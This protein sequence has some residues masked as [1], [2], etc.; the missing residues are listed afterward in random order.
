M[1]SEFHFFLSITDASFIF[2]WDQCLSSHTGPTWTYSLTWSWE[3]MLLMIGFRWVLEYT[4][5]SSLPEK[6]HAFNFKDNILSCGKISK[7]LN[8]S[9]NIIMDSNKHQISVKSEVHY[10]AIINTGEAMSVITNHSTIC[11]LWLFPLSWY[12]IFFKKIIEWVEIQFI[13]LHRSK[14]YSKC[15]YNVGSCFPKA[16]EVI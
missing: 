7:P 2:S 4:V 11:S 6:N 1:H 12:P 13:N 14:Y 16:S 3:K 8:M 5:S 10:L 9:W 15:D